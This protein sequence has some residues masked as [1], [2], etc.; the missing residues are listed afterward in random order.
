M[1]RPCPPATVSDAPTIVLL[2]PRAP[3]F[4]AALRTAVP[5][6][7][8]H[9]FEEAAAAAACLARTAA[10]VLVTVEF[11]PAIAAEASRL[12]W[13]QTVSAGIDPLLPHSAALRHC[14]VT[15]AR[16]MHADQMADYAMAA[17][18]MLRWRFTRLLRDQAARAWR[19][20][21]KTPLAGSTLGVVGLG[22]IGQEIA[23]RARGAHMAVIGV[24]RSGAAVE[25]LDEVHPFG[26][27]DEVLPRCDVLVLVV[28]ATPETVALLDDAA[29]RRMRPGACLI[30]LAR[31]SVVEEPALITALQ[32]GR[33]GGAALDV[34]ATEPLPPDSPLWTLEN[35]IIT[36]HIAGMS[37]DYAE[38]FAAGFA[39]NLARFRRG[40]RLH[41]IVHLDR[42][43]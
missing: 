38:R 21:P 18:V 19:R 7:S 29:L 5:D 26:R 40:E 16:G 17:M 10:D 30:N 34:F 31:G 4:A 8:L 3:V 36:P 35:V 1:R 27:L 24:S 28:P 12:R 39:A 41:N 43:Y 33:L 32:E 6:I 9:A 22:A 11:P 23:R 2:H 37:E 15:N 14:L 42:G 20:A 25:G 13:V